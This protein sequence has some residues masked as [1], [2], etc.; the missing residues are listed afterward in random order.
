MEQ[1]FWN[2]LVRELLGDKLSL[3]VLLVNYLFAFMGTIIRWYIIT[4]DAINVQ[5]NGLTKFSLKYW[6]KN[7]LLHKTL[8]FF[9]SISL[10]FIAIRFPIEFG[11]T[12]VSYPLSVVLGLSLDK[13]SDIVKNILKIKF[14]KSL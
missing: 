5:A 6:I 11:F 14:N 13:L 7:N 12:I 9:A 10:I 2:S 4:K 8:G 3:T 1:N